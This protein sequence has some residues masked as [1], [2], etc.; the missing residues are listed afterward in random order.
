MPQRHL[1]EYEMARYILPRLDRL[2]RFCQKYWNAAS[3]K[4]QI[5][6]GPTGILKCLL[7]NWD[8]FVANVRIM[9]VCQHQHLFRLFESADSEPADHLDKVAEIMEH[10]LSPADEPGADTFLASVYDKV[11]TKLTYDGAKLLKWARH[12]R[13]LANVACQRL[14]PW[15]LQHAVQSIADAS[16]GVEPVSQRQRAA[17]P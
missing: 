16:W 3:L 11:L 14:H 10:D 2:H 6:G 12:L 17:L 15:H 9:A 7:D 13:L 1:S 5:M 8:Y 4:N